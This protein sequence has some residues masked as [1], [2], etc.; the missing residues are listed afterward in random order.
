MPRFGCSRRE[1]VISNPRRLT[2]TALDDTGRIVLTGVVDGVSDQ[3]IAVWRLDED[4]VLD[5]TYGTAGV[6]VAV[7][8]V[9]TGDDTAE[10]LTLDGTGRAVVA[11]YGPSGSDDD[12]AVLRF[13]AAGVLDGTF[14][15]D[16]IVVLSDLAG[17][18]GEDRPAGV[19]VNSSGEV[20]VAGRTANATD[21][22]LFLVRLT[23]AGALDGTFATAGLRLED[24][25]IS[26]GE[27]EA[28]A[29]RLDDNDRPLVSGIATNADNGTVD[30]IVVRYTTAGVRDGTF[31]TNGVSTQPDIGGAGGRDS[32]RGMAFDAAGNIVVTAQILPSGGGVDGLVYRLDSDGDLDTTF[33]TT[34]SYLLTDT[35]GLGSNDAALLAVVDGA[36]RIL[37]LGSSDNKGAVSVVWAFE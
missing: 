22:D 19:A 28:N 33:A 7:D 9:G 34:G 29:L 10:F 17:V 18:A 25:I 27:D 37:A 26:A 13:T 3:D 8:A 16:G 24:A 6:V 5:A 1:R 35:T 20:Y 23:D 2:E 36:G 31:G 30:A 11:A 4:G 32:A 21:N 15:T 14:D 12:V